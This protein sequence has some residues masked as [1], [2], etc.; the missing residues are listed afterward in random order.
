MER[1]GFGKDSRSSFFM[2]Y[3]AIGY[4]L[5]GVKYIDEFGKEGYDPNPVH[6]V[7]VIDDNKD[8]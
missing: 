3:D 6:G 8:E 1:F 2:D 7:I 5:V 4:L